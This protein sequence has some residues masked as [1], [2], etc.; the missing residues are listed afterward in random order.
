[1]KASGDGILT[2]DDGVA[3]CWWAAQTADYGAYHDD[4]WGMPTV[5]DQRL[6]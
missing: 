3:R 5:N 2:G 4:E 1:M 6:F